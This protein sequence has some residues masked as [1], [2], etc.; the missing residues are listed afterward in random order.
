M[1]E[2]M[3]KLIF[4]TWEI[5]KFAIENVYFISSIGNKFIEFI[6]WKLQL[7]AIRFIMD[8]ISLF[9]DVLEKFDIA[10]LSPGNI[11]DRNAKL[12]GT[13]RHFLFADGSDVCI[14]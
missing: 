11:I 1:I 7:K 9:I 5:L 6:D 4:Y 12:C 3:N 10:R 14:V 2:F 8:F 13:A